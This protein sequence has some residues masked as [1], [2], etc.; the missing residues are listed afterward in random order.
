MKK[1]ILWISFAMNI[2]KIAAQTPVDTLKP[3]TTQK[4]VFIF[5]NYPIEYMPSFPGGE[6]ALFKYLKDTI[7]YPDIAKKNNIQGKVYVGF[8]I[9]KEGQITDIVIK[10]GVIYPDLIVSDTTTEKAC[11]IKTIKNPAI[12]SLEAEAKK[13]VANMPKWINE[14]NRAIKYT[15]QIKFALD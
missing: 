5:C 11:F 8:T 3:P 2:C 9:Q 1:S 13:A 14:S 10:R 7:H 12:G 4:P 15:I 6:K